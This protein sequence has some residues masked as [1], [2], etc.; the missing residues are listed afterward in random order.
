MLDEECRVPKGDDHSFLQ[1][2]SQKHGRNPKYGH[3]HKTPTEFIVQHFAGPVSYDTTGFLQ[4]NRDTLNRDVVASM[5]SSEIN[6]LQH[7]FAEEF[8]EEKQAAQAARPTGRGRGGPAAFGG[9][10]RGAG[11][12]AAG[13]GRGGSPTK[14]LAPSPTERK[15]LTIGKRFQ[16][17]LS[18]LVR[19]LT[20]SE[21]HYVRCIKPNDA[22]LPGQFD[23]RK[24]LSQLQNNGVLETIKMRKAGFASHSLMDNFYRR[25][26]AL[27]ISS[28]SRDEVYEFLE[29][30]ANG[31]M[32]QFAV[33][34]TKVFIR[35]NLWETLEQNRRELYLGSILVLQSHIRMYNSRC[36]LNFLAKKHEEKIKAAIKIQGRIRVWHAK[37]ELI[38]LIQKKF[39]E[40]RRKREEEERR[41][42]EEEERKKKEEEKKKREEEERKKREEEE[43]RLRE[44]AERK[45]KEEEELRRRQ[46]E[47]RLALERQKR[48]EEERKR[49]LEEEWKREDEARRSRMQSQVQRQSER[50]KQQQELE[51][52]QTQQLLDED[53]TPVE[54]EEPPPEEEPTEFMFSEPE[55]IQFPVNG[56]TGMD[57]ASNDNLYDASIIEE[58][59]EEEGTYRSAAWAATTLQSFVR[60]WLAKRRVIFLVLAKIEQLR[61]LREAEEREHTA[62]MAKVA[63]Q[64]E[65]HR[66]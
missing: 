30:T 2:L 38:G 29:K 54:V 23:M 55:D 48:E 18:D 15:K 64:Q 14:V 20:S 1:K 46:E 34:N 63:T 49:K 19:I 39:E 53:E 61:A 13:A 58:V 22:S 62:M 51:K 45:R 57:D 40:E 60:C 27:G 44:A 43:R 8:E 6:L 12:G 33:G 59:E 24:T 35:S 10:G 31:D 9:G 26:G 47:E 42:R 56:M 32:S 66:K 65:E 3:S 11:R 25:Y 50:R 41:K 21:R 52:L 4:K 17:S 37:R 16:Q 5:W 28:A 7:I 36:T